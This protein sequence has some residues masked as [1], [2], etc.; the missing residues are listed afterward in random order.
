MSRS[1]AEPLLRNEFKPI[2]ER[3]FQMGK[4]L[5]I[6]DADSTCND[7]QIPLSAITHQLNSFYAVMWPVATTMIVTR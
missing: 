6:D 4:S 5:Q 2:D 7:R 3:E 1:Y